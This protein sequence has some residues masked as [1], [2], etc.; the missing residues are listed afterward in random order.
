[1]LLLE[2]SIFVT[3]TNMFYN[4]ALF[5]PVI[6]NETEYN[7]ICR[8]SLVCTVYSRSCKYNWM[9]ICLSKVPLVVVCADD[10]NQMQHVVLSCYQ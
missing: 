5:F 4:S 6:N 2:I 1:M 3:T 9:M 8:G 10:E 7:F